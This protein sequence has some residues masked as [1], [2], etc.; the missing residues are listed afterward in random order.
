M[1]FRL[2][3]I[4]SA[5]YRVEFGAWFDVL[6]PGVAMQIHPDALGTAAGK[7]ATDIAWE[8]Q[9][10]IESANANGSKIVIATYDYYKY[11]DS[12]DHG[13]AAN[14]LLRHGIP[15]RLVR[16]LQTIW[17]SSTR[18]IRQGAALGPTFQVHNGLG[19]GDA[20]SLLPAILFV[21]WQF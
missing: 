5:L 14:M 8:A 21:S 3:A 16:L 19:Q 15:K 13:F 4:Y 10:D 18:R 20:M 12:F 17:G 9:T 2:L 6:F 7:D 1:D 11:F